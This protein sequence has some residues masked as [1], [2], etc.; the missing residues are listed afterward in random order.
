ME[1]EKPFSTIGN[2][3]CCSNDTQSRNFPT[4]IPT[5]TPQNR[6]SEPTAGFP[7]SYDKVACGKP[8]FLPRINSVFWWGWRGD[9]KKKFYLKALEQQGLGERER[10]EEE[11]T[12]T[13][14]PRPAAFPSR[15]LLTLGQDQAVALTRGPPA[16]NPEGQ[17]KQSAGG[18]RGEGPSKTACPARAA[19]P[20]RQEAPG[21]GSELA[22][23]C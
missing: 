1:S 20:G 18:V 6:S 2:H 19:T 14:S 15:H 11:I 4:L 3:S 16:G 21:R 9:A 5:T 8:E 23:G 17:R 10:G 7:S 22:G 13:E 12:R